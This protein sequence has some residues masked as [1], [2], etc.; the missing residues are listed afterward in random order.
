[1]EKKERNVVI[2]IMKAQLSLKKTNWCIS[3]WSLWLAENILCIVYDNN[4]P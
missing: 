3:S 2:S 1:M 4:H